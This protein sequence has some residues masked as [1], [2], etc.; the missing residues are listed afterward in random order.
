[1][2]KSTIY[3]IYATAFISTIL[4]LFIFIYL[5]HHFDGSVWQSMQ[6]SKA[7]LTAEYCELDQPT[8]FFRQTMNTYSNLMYFFL[9][10]IV[11]LVGFYDKKDKQEINQNPIQKFPAFSVFFGGCL[12]Y[13]SFGS[14]FFHASLTWIGQRVDMNGTYS[15]CIS[16]IGISFYRLLI[17]ANPTRWFQGLFVFTLLLMVFIFIELHLLISSIIL[18]PLLIVLIIFG[19]VLNYSRNKQNF[20]LRFALLSLLLMI[21]AFI[22]RTID[23]KKIA[24][25]PTAIY[26]GHAL[27]HFFT[28]MSAFVLYW[29]YRS[30]NINHK[31]I[32]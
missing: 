18:L 2:Q 10:M 32:K 7:A 27:W 4:L 15:I 1:M 13:L 14:A 6:Q 31:E 28:G 21:G 19:T 8:H 5:N 16:L 3:K 11:V 12:M 26:Q 30:E 23:V 24:C 9:G 29:F 22:L 17:R 20:N 25:N